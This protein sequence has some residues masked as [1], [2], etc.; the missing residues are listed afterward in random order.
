MANNRRWTRLVALLLGAACTNANEVTTPNLR[1]GPPGDGGGE[2]TG[3][4]NNLSVPVI[5]VDGKNLAGGTITDAAST[6]L[7][8]N[9]TQAALASGITTLPWFHTENTP[10]LGAYYCQNTANTW[11]AQWAVGTGTSLDVK[12][13]WGDNLTAQK[14]NINSVIRVETNLQPAVAQTLLGYNMPYAYGTKNSE[15]KC[16]DGTSAPMTPYVYTH[17]ACLKIEK[18]D[19]PKPIDPVFFNGCVNDAVPDGPGGYAAEV[20]VSGLVTYGYNWML[21]Q[22][23]R[24]TAAEKAGLW[25]LTYSVAAPGLATIVPPADLGGRYGTPVVGPGNQTSLE[26]VVSSN[27]SKKPTSPGGGGGQH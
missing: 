1:Y 19:A 17:N 25:R 6:G 8:P 4:G 13:F 3:F 24:F 5:F 12:S 11:M 9:L 2:E 7:R 20:N 26:I 18:I 27:K 10:D 23:T 14:W 16:T 22:D 15:I 21:G